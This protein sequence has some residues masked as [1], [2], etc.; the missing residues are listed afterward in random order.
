MTNSTTT[1]HQI[2][3][4]KP[5]SRS[6]FFEFSN[7]CKQIVEMEDDERTVNEF[8]VD[9]Y[10]T[11]IEKKTGEAPNRWETFNGWKQLGYKVEPGERAYKVW[12]SPK[13][14][15]DGSEKFFVANLFCNLQVTER[16]K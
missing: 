12:S 7:K 4:D 8:M 11:A 15:K 3:N 2:V 5:M 14:M 16:V 9:V 1:E 10:T 13:K 6:Q